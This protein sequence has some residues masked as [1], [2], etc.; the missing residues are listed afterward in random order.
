MQEARATDAD[1]GKHGHFQIFENVPCT[2]QAARRC[3]GSEHMLFMS[4]V[5]L[6][7]FHVISLVLSLSIHN[8]RRTRATDADNGKHTLVFF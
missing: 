8:A 5:S 3:M 6:S 4:S 7:L 2:R 1:N